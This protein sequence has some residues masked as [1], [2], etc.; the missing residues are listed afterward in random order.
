MF[1]TT[2]KRSV[3]TLGVVAGLLAAAV[4]ANAA[5]PGGVPGNQPNDALDTLKAPS[6]ESVWHEA[7]RNG[8]TN[9]DSAGHTALPHNNDAEGTQVGSEGVKTP[10]TEQS[11]VWHEAARTGVV[12]DAPAYVDIFLGVDG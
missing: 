5:G 4:P 8:V 10:S 1:S 2:I 3:A 11:S 9:R 7:A 6:T 12:P